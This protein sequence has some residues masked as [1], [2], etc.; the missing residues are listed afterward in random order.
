M[1]YLQ[2]RDAYANIARGTASDGKKLVVF[3]IKGERI[4][5]RYKHDPRVRELTEQLQDGELS[6][7]DFL[8]VAGGLIGGAAAAA[9]LAAC[10]V[11]PV[12]IQQAPKTDAGTDRVRLGMMTTISGI[13]SIHAPPTINAAQLAIDEINA[14]GGVLGKP[15][16]LLI[17]DNNTNVDIARP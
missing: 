12:V 6:R 14:A 15:V 13:G 1:V 5:S 4:M 16:D 7:R 8:R 3:I 17:E 10:N 11:Q 9:L 2:G